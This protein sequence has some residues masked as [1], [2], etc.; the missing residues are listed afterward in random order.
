MTPERVGNPSWSKLK[1]FI[2]ERKA[3]REGF[4]LEEAS[5]VSGYKLRSLEGII[6]Q[7]AGYDEFQ[8]LEKL[9]SPGIIN[10]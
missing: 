7:L 10:A 2:K 3:N 5:E 8:S 4:S 9:G 1:N 6:R